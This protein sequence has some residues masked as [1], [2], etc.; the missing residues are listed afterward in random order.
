MRN[1]PDKFFLDS[2]IWFSYFHGSANC[3][4][5][6]EAHLE[7]KIKA[8]ISRHVLEEV[9][10]NLRKK[11]PLSIPAFKNFM[12]SYPPIVLK[13]PTKIT[14][15]VKVNVDSKDQIILQSAVNAKV[16][17]FVTGNTKD[18]SVE[19]LKKIYKIEILTPKQAVKKLKL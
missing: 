18:F 16:K 1:T 17:Y 4:K 3:E 7:G 6:L 19:N 8:V 14:P 12:G 10:I 9:V 15:K 2:N 13:N 11:L 5:I